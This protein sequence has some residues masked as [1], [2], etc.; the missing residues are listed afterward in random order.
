[1]DGILVFAKVK[2]GKQ[3]IGT[4]SDMDNLHDEVDETL[5]MI[6][7]QD[8]TDDIYFLANGEEYKL[9]IS[10]GMAK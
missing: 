4:S 2:G 10:S 7:R 6:N 9:Y 8:L 3:F 1:M 5:V